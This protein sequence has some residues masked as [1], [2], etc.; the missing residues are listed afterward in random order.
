MQTVAQSFAAAVDES[1]E[2]ESKQ[3]ATPA[4][5]S[6]AVVADPSAI[7]EGLAFTLEDFDGVLPTPE[8]LEAL[9]AATVDDDID[10]LLTTGLEPI[11]REPTPAPVAEISVAGSSSEAHVAPIN[12]LA[13][14][15]KGRKPKV[16]AGKLARQRFPLPQY[17]SSNE[18]DMKTVKKPSLPAVAFE[19]EAAEEKLFL[20]HVKNKKYH[21]AMA[22]LPEEQKFA[23][24]DHSDTIAEYRAVHPQTEQNEDIEEE[25]VYVCRALVKVQRSAPEDKGKAKAKGKGKKGKSKSKNK[26]KETGPGAITGIMQVTKPCLAGQ[27]SRDGV[28]RHWKRTHLGIP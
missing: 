10:Y 23:V 24:L 26:T 20:E 21:A 6:Q 22:M 8:E 14:A 27:C 7:P 1:S 4:K 19:F 3:T 11:P 18:L 9:M 13:G 28:N 16:E 5:V 25:R 2:P 15:K 12:Q 17:I